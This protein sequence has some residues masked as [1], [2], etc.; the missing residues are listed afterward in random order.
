MPEKDK[1]KNMLDLQNLIK[2]IRN[3]TFNTSKKEDE[4]KIE[5]NLSGNNVEEKE[6]NTR[7]LNEIG[8][9]LE[10]AELQDFLKDIEIKIE[11]KTSDKK[12]IHHFCNISGK[13]YKNKIIYAPGDTLQDFL[14]RLTIELSRKKTEWF[15]VG[16]LENLI[17]RYMLEIKGRTSWVTYNQREIIST[18]KALKTNTLVTLH[19]HPSSAVTGPL[20]GPSNNDIKSAYSFY[21]Q[22]KNADLDFIDD[23]IISGNSYRAHMNNFLEKAGMIELKTGINSFL[24]L[25]LRKGDLDKFAILKCISKGRIPVSISQNSLKEFQANSLD[26]KEKTIIEKTYFLPKALNTLTGIEKEK[27]KTIISELETEGL[28]LESQI[29]LESM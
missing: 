14:N 28:H 29:V 21:F 9:K 11:T 12:D 24:Y 22:C 26:A 4:A 15:I 17:P 2:W 5:H 13:D 25:Y 1:D 8:E 23:F 16:F 20:L 19:N 7:R 27:I 6:I 18:A 10:K 3:K